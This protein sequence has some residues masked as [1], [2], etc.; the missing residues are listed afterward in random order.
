MLALLLASLGVLTLAAPASAGGTTDIVIGHPDGSFVVREVP[1]ATAASAVATAQGQ[2]GVAW[3]EVDVPMHATGQVTPNDPEFAKQW[4]MVKT[5][6]PEAWSRTTGDSSAVIAV[7]DTGVDATHPD[8]AGAV[9]P[10]AD[11]VGD[12]KTG[13][14]A[15]HGTGVAGV[16]AG[17]GNNAQGIA[18]Y[19]WG[20]KI[21]PVRSLDAK[22]S[23]SSASVASGIQ[24]ATTHGADVINLSLAGDRSSTTLD[25]AIA[26]ARA[27]G[28]LVVAA[29][30]N[31]TKVVQDLTLPQYPAATDG[32]IG[33]AATNESDA[34]YTWTFRGPWAD[35][36]APGCVRTTAPGGAYDDECGTS[37]AAPAVAGILGLALSAFPTAPPAAIEQALYDTSV[38]LSNALAAHGRVDATALLDALAPTFGTK[39]VPERVAGANRIATAV[40]LSKKAHAAADTVVL[41]RADSYAD[42]LGA[43]PLAGRFSA[44]V[45][46]TGS[47]A[48]DPAVSAEIR[49]LGATTVW[50]AGGNSALSPAVAE[51][52]RGLGIS[53]VR[54]LA[55]ATRY[56]TARLIAQEL[57]STSAYVVQAT[58]WP[59]AVAVSGL[60]ALTKAPILLVDKTSVPAATSQALTT[61]GVTNVT[62]V[63]DTSM[64]SDAV[65]ASMRVGSR[66]VTR[67]AGANRYETSKLVAATASAT[68]ADAKRTWLATGVDWPDA[69][70]A[71]PAAAAQGAVLLLVDGKSASTPAVTSWI[72]A[73]GGLTQLVI[74]GGEA[75]VTPMA[76]ATV[77]ALLQG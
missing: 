75:S 73:T 48:L 16:I 36:T 63:G 51:A 55:G 65:L 46:L 13:D 54:R 40:A 42:A 15:G 21:L 53:D 5:R 35:L 64:V 18:G 47:T 17:R 10:G 71:G 45:L 8:L 33:V 7:V 39:V 31:Q 23:G 30:G 57:G 62:V 67:V 2:P 34:P 27:A 50:L 28:V 11:F 14:P 52:L 22:G 4:G 44:P 26:Q 6:A 70:A 24:W 20:C 49:R 3:A 43:A 29:A 32:V 12:G 19:C 76:V 37:F 68:G 69:L 77:A 60:A 9:L 59:S 58:D 74:V 72:Q 25:V 56:D 41:A 61:L 1:A 38:S 66:A